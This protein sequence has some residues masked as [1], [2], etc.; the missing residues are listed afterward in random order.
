[1]NGSLT[2]SG[3]F[4]DLYELTMLS[5]YHAEAVDD[6]ATFELWVRELPQ[7]RNFLVVAG[8]Q[9]V[10]DHLLA[11]QFD[12]G[13]LSYLRSLEMFTPEF[14]DHL[15]DLR[16]TGDLWAMPEGNIAFAGEPLLRVRARRIEA[17]LVETFLLA[18]VTFETMIA[19]KAARV[20]LASGARPF[21]DFSARRAHGAAAAVQV[22][23]AAFIGGAASTSNVEAGRR[24]GIPVSGTMA[25]SFVLS[26]PDELS[27]FRAYARSYPEGGTLLVDTYSTSSGVANAISVAKELEATG[28]YLGAVR[29]DSGDLAA[30][31]RVVR[32]MLDS[33]GLAEVRVVASGDLDEFAIERLVAD[34]APIDAFGVGTRLG[35]SA[36]APS[37][38]GVYK[39]VED[40]EGGRYKT[41]TNKLTVPFTKQV[42]R[43]SDGDGAF[44]HDT[45]ARDGESGI[46]GTPLLVPVIKAGKRVRENDELEAVRR[47]CR[48]GLS[49]LPGQL[50]GLRTA[51]HQYRVDWSPALSG[52]VSPS[53][54]KPRRPEGERPRDRFGRPLPWGSESELELLD[55]ESLPP[56]RSHEMAVDYFNEQMFFPAHE[57]WEAAWRHTQGT[58]DEAFF[59]GL[60]K[61]GA[62]F[63]HIQRGNAQGAWTLIGKAADRIE[64][65]GPAHRGIDVAG[66]CREL[67]A[68]V[69]DLEGAG[70]HSPEHPRD[71]T[72]PTIHGSP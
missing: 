7:D 62:G 24:F 28:G 52:F 27:A 40:N 18:T 33:A 60:A 61:L 39:L 63:T 16:F 22:A 19:T 42:Y 46:E 8:L 29:I 65:Y 17:Q 26:F 11:L 23:R 50:H 6:L 13:D 20:A 12:D 58:G 64:P 36:D 56:A 30:E 57:A 43:R 51:D 4:T 14:L 53:R 71:I 54:L 55:Y 34:G 49:Q 21:A 66:L 59:N 1:M 3:L 68:V 44:A 5:A 25:H 15:R 72:F 48:E 70:R 10:V 37:L 47:R 45:I 32:S 41:S 69:R 67:R 31:A 9:E 38:G 2:G 35:T